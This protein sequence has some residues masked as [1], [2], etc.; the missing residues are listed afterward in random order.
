MN[1]NAVK[2]VIEALRELPVMNEVLNILEKKEFTDPDKPRKFSQTVIGVMSPLTR[3]MFTFLENCNKTFN[4]ASSQFISEGPSMCS[5]LD[6]GCLSLVEKEEHCP[7]IRSLKAFIVEH[8][9]LAHKDFVHNFMMSILVAQFPGAEKIRENF[10]IVTSNRMDS[11]PEYEKYEGWE[12]MHLEQLME[13]SIQGSFL[14]TIAEILE[15]GQ[16]TDVDDPTIEGDLVIREMTLLEKAMFTFVN[17]T[18]KS[19]QPLEVEHNKLLE[20][21]AFE[22]HSGL[23]ITSESFMGGMAEIISISMQGLGKKSFQPKDRTHPEFIR[24][25]ELEKEIRAKQEEINP[26]RNIMWPIINM[27]IDPS[28]KNGYDT[29][30]IRS[31][32]QIVVFNENE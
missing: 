26:V 11:I 9:M 24:V 22:V 17:N 7:Y 28:Q 5:G 19:L 14:E 21:E 13:V 6:S 16:F 2:L 18:L 8:P 27:G 10:E 15:S 4:E 23:E 3:A 29:T 12:N 20:G 25:E 31:G 30:G 32:F 1:E